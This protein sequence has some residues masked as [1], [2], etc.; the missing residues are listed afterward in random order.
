MYCK[1]LLAFLLA[2][3]A[4]CSATAPRAMAPGFDVREIKTAELR[5]TAAITAK[6]PTAWVYEYTPDAVVMFP[7]EQ[8]VAGR[9]ALLQLAHEMKPI[10]AG[11]I[12]SSHV[13]GSGNVAYSYGT[14]SWVS[15]RPPQAS[16]TSAYQQILAWRKEPDGVWRISLEAFLPLATQ[17]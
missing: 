11:V 4:A 12:N 6:D 13:E 17:K 8:P 7:G 5:V 3:L 15:G 14:A 2:G 10:T 9:A 16:T 1:W